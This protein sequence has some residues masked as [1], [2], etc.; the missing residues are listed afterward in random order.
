M[1]SP[2]PP[3][4]AL[5]PSTT[6]WY[7]VAGVCLLMILPPIFILLITESMPLR[8]PSEGW[9]SSYSYTTRTFYAASMAAFGV[10][11]QLYVI[12]PWA[13][14]T[15]GKIVLT[16]VISGLGFTRVVVLLADLWAFPVPWMIVLGVPPWML[17]FVV[18]VVLIIGHRELMARP[19]VQKEL[20]R[21]VAILA[22]DCSLIIVYPS[23]NA[24]FLR[25][26]GLHQLAFLVLLP[27]IKLTMRKLIGLAVVGS[28]EMIPVILIAVDLFDALF[29]AKCMQNTT[30]L[31]TGAGLIALDA[32][33]NYF[34]IARLQYHTRDVQSSFAIAN[35]EACGNLLDSMKLLCN[36]PATL[37]SAGSGPLLS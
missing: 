28:G 12:T 18:V 25:L 31:W 5:A 8:H 6:P 11:M 7:R 29:L 2:A 14:L 24:V 21:F 4:S 17:L 26:S 20:M 33:E 22:V 19:E 23:Y 16:A 3:L 35:G 36:V 30:S 15:L 37:S 34:G 1:V 27:I 9:R 13:N 10:A 32:M